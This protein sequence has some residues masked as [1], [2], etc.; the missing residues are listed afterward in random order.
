QVLWFTDVF[1]GPGFAKFLDLFF[2]MTPESGGTLVPMP[3]SALPIDPPAVFDPYPSCLNC[4]GSQ[5]DL[6]DFVPGAV[7]VAGVTSVVRVGEVRRVGGVA[8]AEVLS[9]AAWSLLG[10]VLA[11]RRLSGVS[12]LLC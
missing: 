2:Y 10:F 9:W 11:A 3:A 8:E 6:T 4:R 1:S 12:G 7:V 5:L